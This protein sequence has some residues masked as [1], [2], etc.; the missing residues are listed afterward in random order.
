MEALGTWVSA[1]HRKSS[2]FQVQFRVAPLTPVNIICGN[3]TPHIFIG[4]WL[5]NTELIL[6]SKFDY[7][8]EYENVLVIR[9]VMQS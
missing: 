7:I 5:Y 4:T 3:H 2:P 9:V 8:R 1:G 6:S